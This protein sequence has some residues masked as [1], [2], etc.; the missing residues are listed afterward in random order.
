MARV[1]QQYGDLTKVTSRIQENDRES[2]VQQIFM[3]YIKI[4]S[5]LKIISSRQKKCGENAQKKYFHN[6]HWCVWE[7]FSEITNHRAACV[8]LAWG[9]MLSTLDN[10]DEQTLSRCRKSSTRSHM[11]CDATHL[12]L[13]NSIYQVEKN[14]DPC[15]KEY[16]DRAALHL[17][18]SRAKACIVAEF[19]A[20]IIA[21]IVVAMHFQ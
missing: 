20:T 14:I 13:I 3:G 2:E 6:K 5:K 4:E 10:R 1:S 16:P 12:P 17:T 21:D 7:A 15:N 11:R 8:A 9:I 18:R 19:V